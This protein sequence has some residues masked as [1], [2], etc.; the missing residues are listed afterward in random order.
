[1]NAVATVVV[2][3]GVVV[4]VEVVEVV[5]KVFLGWQRWYR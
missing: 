4:V 3:V 1:M 2:K 5:R